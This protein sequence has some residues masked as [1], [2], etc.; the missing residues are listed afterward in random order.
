MLFGTLPL[1]V[2]SLFGQIH[3]SIELTSSFPVNLYQHGMREYFMTTKYAASIVIPS[4]PQ[5][6]FITTFSY[7]QQ[8][9]YNQQTFSPHGHLDAMMET[10][11]IPFTSDMYYSEYGFFTG[12]RLKTAENRIQIFATGQMGVTGTKYGTVESVSYTTT[13]ELFSEAYRA[14]HGSVINVQLCAQYGAGLLWHPFSG[15]SIAADLHAVNH[16]TKQP[17][18][19]YRSIGVQFGL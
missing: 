1:I 19:V 9:P 6:D 16:L 4:R 8:Q 17:L 14:E 10:R 18:D 11:Y 2:G 12:F 3:P 5:A 15:L 13:G 7:T